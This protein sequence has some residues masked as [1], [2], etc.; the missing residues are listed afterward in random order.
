MKNTILIVM[1]VLL[2]ATSIFYWQKSRDL[3]TRLLLIQKRIE[4]SKKAIKD[5][6]ALREEA[7]KA[8]K[9]RAA[10]KRGKVKIA[11]VLDDWGYN[12]KN[13]EGL[14]ELDAPI[15]LSILPG[16]PYS[17]LIARKAHANGNE[18]LLHLPLEPH[19]NIPLE[20]E[21]IMTAM[22][23]KEVAETTDRL[24][25]S[26]P[27]LKGLS[28]HMGSKATEDKRLMSIV[29][30]RMK[31]RKLYFLDS[32]VTS[33]SVCRELSR[34]IGVKFAARSV[35]LDNELSSEYIKEKI[36]E[37]AEKALATGW[38]VGI[39]HDRAVTIAALAEMIP[40]L[41]EMEIEIVP[42]SAIAE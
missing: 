30:K 32:L 24:I 31:K 6:R 29:F 9:K 36:S 19:E 23:D 38:A 13:V 35:F 2:A 27:H 3:S 14:F 11:I 17:Q 12:L 21:T 25:S 34:D 37:L 15:T 41:R 42:A 8:L 7:E 39:G 22:T 1:I 4:E 33:R 20:K 26:V 40:K 10:K 18:V 28:N 5:E 16:L